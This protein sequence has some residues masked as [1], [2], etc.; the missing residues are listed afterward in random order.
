MN[1][2]NMLLFSFFISFF[3]LKIIIPCLC[4]DLPNDRSLHSK[5]IPRGG[6]IIFILISLLSLPLTRF[7]SIFLFLP[8]ALVSFLDDLY[9][10]SPKIR[11]S[12]HALTIFTFIKTN[13]DLILFS[14]NLY[15]HIFIYIFLILLGTSIINFSN[16]VDGINGLLIST[17]II[18]FVNIILVNKSTYLY[19]IIGSQLAFYYFNRTPAKVFMGDIGSTFLGSFL[20]LE[21]IRSNSFNDAFIILSVAFPVM[22]D[23]FSCVIRRYFNNENIFKPHK[24]HLYQRLVKAGLSHFKVTFIYSICSIIIFLT[25]LTENVIIVATTLFLISIFGFILD[26]YKAEPFLKN[27]A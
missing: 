21:I 8:L 3:L 25:C 7:Y 27:N 22:F 10:L 14:D 2:L 5:P 9:S 4:I 11:Y 6:G 24:K 15:L 13:P 1:N 16:F 26:K 19:P 20:Y 18:V 12:V 23:A 17:M